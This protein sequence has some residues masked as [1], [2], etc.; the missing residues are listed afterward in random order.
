MRIGQALLETKLAACVHVTGPIDSIFRWKDKVEHS[1]EWLCT[2]K[3]RAALY[4][5]CEATILTLHP[6]ET[7]EIVAMRI[8][9]TT[10][11]YAAWLRAETRR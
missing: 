8:E 6:Y 11:A 10:A 5:K 3:T 1:Q 4:K 7:P 2:I 9:K